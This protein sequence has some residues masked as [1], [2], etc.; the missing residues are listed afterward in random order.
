[1]VCNAEGLQ[2][3]ILL[4]GGTSETAAIA[5]T[6][7]EAGY[8]ILVSTATTIPFD[9][10]RHPRI[11]RRA[12]KLTKDE[13]MAL[14]LES[15]INGIV[16]ASHPYAVE[17]RTVAR[18]LA[19]QVGIPYLTLIRPSDIHDR[20][21][22]FTAENHDAAASKAFAH[23]RPVLLTTG[24]KH[25]APYVQE[26][27]RLNLPL[28]VRVL[29]EETSMEACRLAGIDDSAVIAARGPFSVEEN[30][31]IIRRF[32]I[33]VLV[34]KDSGTAGGTGEKL[35]AA[36]QEGCHA[37]VVRRPDSAGDGYSY[38]NPAALIQAVLAAIPK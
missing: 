17:V 37:I 16:D 4:L 15:G 23:G 20:Q 34:T 36:R 7:A 30:R 32:G 1:M 22:V 12:G 24:A 13:M 33:G 5:L 31:E 19:N 3:V 25:L 14:V 28:Y 9:T 10:G 18:H 38:D 35:T 26:S 27:Q 11:I 2:V 29:P 8:D 6:L 21:G